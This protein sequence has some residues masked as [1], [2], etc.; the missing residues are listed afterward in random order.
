[1]VDTAVPRTLVVN[2]NA[3]EL[4]QLALA[5]AAG[6]ALA[7]YVRPYVNKGR[8]WERALS[9]LPLAGS[10]YDATFG[11][12]RVSDALL[13]ALTHEAGVLPDLCAAA[14]GRLPGLPATVRHHCTNRLTMAVREAVARAACRQVAG[15]DCVVAYEGFALPAFAAAQA[16]GGRAAVLNYPVAHHRQRRRVR[17]E[18]NERE[19]D[20][21]VTWPDFDDWPAGHEERLDEEIRLADAVLVGSTYASDSFVA[22]GI[23]RAKMRVVPYGVDLQIFK[24]APTPPRSAHF[25]VIYAGQLTQRK[26]L[27][28]LLRGYRKFERRDS[29]LTLV[30]SPVGSTEP[31]RPYA[32][33]FEHVRHQTR[34]ALAAMYRAADVFVFP[35]LIEGMPLVVLEAMACGLPVIVTANGPADIVR[36]GID[37]F[38]IP[39]RDENAICDRLER[40]YRAPDLRVQM[41]RQAALRAR[42]F[43]WSA[44]AAK[45]CLALSELAGHTAT[46]IPHPAYA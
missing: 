8:G 30:G 11:R 27:A 32:D 40:L 6:N 44:Y 22:E 45:A 5:L 31:L 18:E 26:G 1:M 28:Y 23:D 41:G 33:L 46:A 25:S 7:A 35:T 13:A 20:F 36:D 9:A 39:E 17:L 2:F 10:L 4:N 14:I 12:R 19:P 3:P 38:V 15:V 24:P 42:E 43:A 34:P 21:A 37:G 16:L 29:R